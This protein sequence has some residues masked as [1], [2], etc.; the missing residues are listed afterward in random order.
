MTLYR[1]AG[2]ASAVCASRCLDLAISV[3]N[4]FIVAIFGPGFLTVKCPVFSQ[5]VTGLAFFS[6]GSGVYPNVVAACV[7]SLRFGRRTARD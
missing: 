3:A 2:L 4:S 1:L 7:I 6:A 5:G